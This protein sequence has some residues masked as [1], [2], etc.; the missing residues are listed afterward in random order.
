MGRESPDF[1]QGDIYQVQPAF[2]EK[3]RAA[4]RR[5]SP[6]KDSKSK[7]MRTFT[8]EWNGKLTMNGEVIMDFEKEVPILMRNFECPLA[9]D[10][11]F[12]PDI[13]WLML[14]DIGRAQEEKDQMEETQ[15]EDK[16]R[17]N[18]YGYK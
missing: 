1:L 12:R 9:S 2:M 7:L 15:R 3:F 13:Q 4:G 8:G 10:C 18:A 11:T 16:K 17:R 14:K 5:L 6:R